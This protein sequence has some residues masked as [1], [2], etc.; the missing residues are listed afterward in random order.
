MLSGLPKEMQDAVR[1]QALTISTWLAAAIQ[2]SARKS[3]NPQA[4]RLASTVKAN[5]D[6][7]VSVSAGGSKRVFE[8][9]SR[10]G[11]QAASAALFATE[12]GLNPG[13]RGGPHGFQR[14]VGANSYWF[15]ATVDA[16]APKAAAE[17][18]AMV[19]K[20]VAEANNSTPGVE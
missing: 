5:R 17:W 13:K 6:R 11:S 18:Q 4:K 7:V 3:L 20:I 14:H 19:N 12:F 10:G 1:T 16:N 9:S 8:G 2:Q 15:I